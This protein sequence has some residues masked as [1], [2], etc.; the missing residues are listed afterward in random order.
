M[1]SL[2]TPE[3]LN[4]RNENGQGW[5]FYKHDGVLRA[6]RTTPEADMEMIRNVQKFE[7]RDD[8]VIIAAYPKCG[9]H[10]LW[11]IVTM[12][13]A[14]NSEY[15]KKSKDIAML[16]K[17]TFERA[18]ELPSPRVLN[19]HLYFR[20][21]PEK[22]VEKRIKTIFIMRN[23][24]DV[25][26]SYF[27]HAKGLKGIYNFDGTYSEYLDLFLEG[28]VPGGGYA[29][30]VKDWQKVKQDNPDLPILTLLYENL[31]KDPV[32]N[33]KTVAEFIGESVTDELCEQIAEACS[34]KKMK[35]ADAEV[36]EDLVHPT[37]MIYRKGEVGDWKNWITV[38]QN[39]RFDDVIDRNLEGTGIV[40]TYE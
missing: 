18:D 36:K 5:S 24:K 31:K 13:R 10:W 7:L 4:Y 35:V 40:F 2:Q 27:N 1:E 6:F 30:Y 34:F 38:A 39:E 12:L 11:E 26:V 28:K 33:I 21:L 17:P 25:S 29:D 3:I 37:H 23:P 8:D 15:N 22:L 19:S 9:T 14:G 32:K 20:Q 16:G